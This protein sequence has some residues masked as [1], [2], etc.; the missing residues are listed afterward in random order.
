MSQVKVLT[1]AMGT[2]EPATILCGEAGAAG[3]IT[4]MH[5]APSSASVGG[6]RTG[7]GTSAE[8]QMVGPAEK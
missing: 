6:T 3:S 4:E 2:R 8:A 1:F 7:Q 5:R